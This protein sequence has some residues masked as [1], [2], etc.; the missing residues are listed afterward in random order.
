MSPEDDQS[1]G[2]TKQFVRKVLRQENEDN[3]E[4]EDNKDMN[5]SCRIV[6][7]IWTH[8]QLGAKPVQ[9]DHP[10]EYGRSPSRLCKYPLHPPDNNHPHH[11]CNSYTYL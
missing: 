6:V 5:K 1:Q 2:N 9:Q 4:N 10:H 11:H 7:I 3:D 8:F